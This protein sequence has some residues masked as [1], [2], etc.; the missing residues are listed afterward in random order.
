L[1]I[2]L[3]SGF[4]IPLIFGAK[5]AGAVFPL[6][7]LTI[8]LVSRSF[9]IFLNQFLDYQGLAKKRFFNSLISMVLNIILNMLLIPKYGAV[10]ASIAT[11][12]A[13]TPYVILNWLEVQKVLNK[14]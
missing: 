7:I 12:I 9:L 14:K 11:S 13:Y 2:L 3:F 6:Q 1:G 8:F 5:Y 4:L 10:G